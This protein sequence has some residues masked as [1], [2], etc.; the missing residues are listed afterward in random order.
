MTPD[1]PATPDK[2]RSVFQSIPPE[3]PAG[4]LVGVV[5]AWAYWPTFV[6]LFEK[7]QTDPQYSHGYLVPLFSLYLLWRRPNPCTTAANR[8]SWWGMP[9]VVVGLALAFAGTY[10]YFDWFN[11]VSLLPVLAG[12][13]VL[14][15]GWQVL[16]WAWPAI[17]FLIFMIPL[18]YVLETALAQPLR[19]IAT[20]AGT[21]VLQ[22]LGFAAHYTGNIIHLQGAPAIGVEDA[23]CGLSMLLIFFALCTA[24][25]LLVRRPPWEKAV[26]FLSAVPIA[27]LSNVVR[28]VLTAI[29]YKTADRRL[30]DDFFHDWAGLLMMPVALVF[31]FLELRLLSWLVVRVPVEGVPILTAE[32]PL[33]DPSKPLRR[34]RP[35][36]PAGN[37]G[38]PEKS[39]AVRRFSGEPAKPQAAGGNIPPRGEP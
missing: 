15:G 33:P 36:K 20:V 34:R 23:C 31:L 30:V 4:A 14:M 28:V 32:L 6:T 25:I 22:T 21:Y 26:I 2:P 12:L 39:T 37:G 16:R 38:L 13:C 27:L 8:P 19:R 3:V 24:V 11:A 10:A 1:M 35:K 29:L 9:I 5:L 7:W 17:A 18:P